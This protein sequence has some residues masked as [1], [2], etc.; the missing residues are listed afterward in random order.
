MSQ[1][2]VARRGRSTARNGL[3]EVRGIFVSQ[4]ANADGKQ[5]KVFNPRI[6]KPR[7]Y[8]EALGGSL[9]EMA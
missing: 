9:A 7:Y 3:V 1:T 6:I 5:E 4:L 2:Q 8:M